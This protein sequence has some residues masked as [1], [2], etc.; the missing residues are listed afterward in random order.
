[1]FDLT[2]LSGLCRKAAG[3]D[4]SLVSDEELLAA[5]VEWQSVRSAV[6]VA[7]ARAL[8][9]LQVRGLTDRQH[10]LKTAQWVAAEA[11]VDRG[12]VSRRMR[13][14][15]RL[16]RLPSVEAAVASGE[17][18]ADHAAVLADAVANPGSAIRSRPPRGCGSIWL[19]PPR[20]S[21]GPTRWA[22]RWCCSI[23]TAA[24]TPT[25]TWPAT[26]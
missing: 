1:M 6:D 24:M 20:S 4:P 8:A 15:M 14:G 25:G 10:G 7:E 13:L 17:L 3:D 5:V 22:A 21:I 23:R 12:G 16:R 26:G 19:T 9:E 18:S 2:E 11:K